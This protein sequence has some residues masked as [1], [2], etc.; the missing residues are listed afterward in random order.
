MPFN[1]EDVRK[2]DTF[3]FVSENSRNSLTFYLFCMLFFNDGCF[4]HEIVVRLRNRKL[5]PI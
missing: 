3:L 5:A 1:M 4:R 2:F